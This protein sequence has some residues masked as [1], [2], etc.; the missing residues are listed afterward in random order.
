[1][2]KKPNK[3]IILLTIHL[4]NKVN[5]MSMHGRYGQ[6]AEKMGAWVNMHTKEKDHQKKKL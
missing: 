1:M 3:K 5:F 4:A 2:H 6:L